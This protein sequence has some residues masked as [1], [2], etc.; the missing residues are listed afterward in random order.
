MKGMPSASKPENKVIFDPAF[1]GNIPVIS[2][3]KIYTR[4]YGVQYSEMAIL[5]LS[6]KA[7]DHI[8]S[9]SNAQVIIPEGTNT[10]FYIDASAWVKLVK[11][12]E[13]KYASNMAALEDYETE[14]ER[15]GNEYVKAAKALAVIAFDKTSDKDILDAYCDYQEKLLRYSEF[16]WTAFILNNFVAEQ[17]TAILD[18]YLKIGKDAIKQKRQEYIDGV[19]HPARNAAVLELACE[20]A[21]AKGSLPEAKM[22]ELY[23]KYNWLP[24]LDLFN[25]PWTKSEFKDAVAGMKKPPEKE[26]ITIRQ[27]AGELGLNPEDEQ[28]LNVAQHFV[29]IKDARDDFRRQGICIALPFFRM[30]EKRMGI[31]PK[32][33]RYVTSDEVIA[34]LKEKAAARKDAI[35]E[36]KDGFAVYLDRENRIAC[37]SGAQITTALE[38]FRLL[39]K[40]VGLKEIRGMTASKGK[41]AGKVAI[42]RG[43]ADLAKVKA[44]DVL[45][46]VTTHPDYTIAMRKAAAIITDEGGITSHAAIVAREFSIPCIVGTHCATKLLQNG[47]KVEVDADGGIVR[48]VG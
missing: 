32:E 28:Y 14:F 21:N 19:F 22:A 6:D 46:A 42:V 41:A 5:S 16:T 48:K 29:Y 38:S 27:M 47:D 7:S 24:C 8:T 3:K 25:D 40:Q 10:I 33:I 23:E 2:W 45:V 26:V 43:I 44:G 20:V 15:R 11:S 34:F 12:L 39:P 13:E 35:E 31:E 4:E 30:I 17:A 18:K 36:R 1:I 9:N 37:I